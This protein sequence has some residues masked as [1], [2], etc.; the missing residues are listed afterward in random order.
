MPTQA[1]LSVGFVVVCAE[2]ED[3]DALQGHSAARWVPQLDVL[4]ILSRAGRVGVQLI[5]QE[6]PVTPGW[7]VRGRIC[8]SWSHYRI[9]EKKMTASVY[10]F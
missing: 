1:D 4:S 8:T 6:V 10:N 3:P 7:E 5:D 2:K 9:K